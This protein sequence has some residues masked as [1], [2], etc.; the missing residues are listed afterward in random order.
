MER[1]WTVETEP[2][3]RCTIGC[4]DRGPYVEIVEQGMSSGQR[5]RLTPLGASQLAVAANEC[6]SVI[7][8]SPLRAAS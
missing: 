6:E 4:D 5:V 3:G 8:R 2:R 1:T 7:G